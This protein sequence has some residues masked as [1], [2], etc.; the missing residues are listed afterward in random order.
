MIE[1]FVLDNYLT[2]GY[3]N[4]EKYSPSKTKNYRK[5]NQKNDH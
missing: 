3:S 2:R 4:Q 5:I 1:H